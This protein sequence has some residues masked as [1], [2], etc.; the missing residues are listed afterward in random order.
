MMQTA[1]VIAGTCACPAAPVCAHRRRI[2]M[3]LHMDTDLA[4][5]AVPHMCYLAHPRH[6]LRMHW[7]DDQALLDRTGGP[8]SCWFCVASAAAHALDNMSATVRSVPSAFKLLPAADRALQLYSARHM[9][10]AHRGAAPKHGAAVLQPL[11]SRTKRACVLM[12][13]KYMRGCVHACCKSGGFESPGPVMPTAVPKYD[14]QAPETATAARSYS[15][16]RGSERLGLGDQQRRN[17]LVS[18]TVA[19]H[20]ILQLLSSRC[21][22]TLLT[23]MDPDPYTCRPNSVSRTV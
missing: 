7:S 4:I 3:V 1:R 16:Q 8:M 15:A 22:V 12:D 14:T 2:H 18:P 13:G 11:R 5:L 21:R 23:R 10:G 6:W 17:Y 19:V 9:P 20:L